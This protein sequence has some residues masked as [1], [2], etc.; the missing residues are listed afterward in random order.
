MDFNYEPNKENDFIAF[1][2]VKGKERIEKLAEKIAAESSVGTWTDVKTMN[3]YVWEHLRARVFKIVKVTENS[4]FVYIAYPFE[5]FDEKN[6]LQF[7]A[8]VMGNLFGMKSLDEIKLLDIWFPKRYQRFFDGARFGIEGIR[9]Y[10]GTK[11]RPH[12]GTIVKPK[13]GLH[14]KEF[15]EVAKEA[16]LGGLDLVKD[17]ENLVDQKFCPFRERFFEMMKVIDKVE[18]ETGEKKI[19]VINITDKYSR[20][21]ERIDFLRE[22]G[23]NQV[24][25]DV[26]II[27]YGALLDILELLHKYKFIVHAHRAGHAAIDRGKIGINFYVFEKIYRMFGV[28]QLHVGTG[29]GKMEGDEIFVYNTSRLVREMEVPEDFVFLTLGQEFDEGTIPI[30]PVASGGLHPGHIDAVVKVHTKDVVIQAGGGVH[31]HPKGTYYGAKAMRQAVEAVEKGISI[32][33]YAKT[34][35]ELK[36][37]IEKWG[38]YDPKKSLRKLEFVLK[39]KE[40]CELVIRE[41]G[42]EGFDVI[43][44]NAEKFE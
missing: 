16:Y 12:I 41:R 42:L 5:H 11:D 1:F 26:V 33:E 10:L 2:W 24:M 25:L 39:N 32:P 29:V 20:M 13:V 30:F 18:K 37:A 15:A 34:H 23:W 9:K 40:F 8:S 4:G 22:H 28:D 17:D 31:G 36:M 6:F 7:S 3:R 35:E 19:Y 38:Y 43:R 44:R 14:P 21:V 27:G